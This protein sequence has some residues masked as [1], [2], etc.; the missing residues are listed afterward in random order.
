MEIAWKLPS[1]MQRPALLNKS[2]H[3]QNVKRNLTISLYKTEDVTSVPHPGMSVPKSFVVW[4]L[5]L[6]RHI[7]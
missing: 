1:E 2:E 6:L 7:R 5:F 4:R 3:Y